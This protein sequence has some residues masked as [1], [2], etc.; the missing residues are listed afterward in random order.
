MAKKNIVKYA[1]AWD[2]KSSVGG[3]NLALEGG[4]KRKLAF[5]NP[6]EFAALVAL[7]AQD[8]LFYD[9]VKGILGT[10]TISTAP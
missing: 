8:R 7:F 10:R 9:D 4:A 5:N 2:L 3:A 1:L 6:A